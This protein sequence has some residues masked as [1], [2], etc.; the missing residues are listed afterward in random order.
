MTPSLSR[1]AG[2][3]VLGAASTLLCPAPA[4]AET[5]QLVHFTDYHSHAVASPLYGQSEWGGVAR[6][7]R[8]LREQ[9]VGTASFVFSGGD[10]LNRGAPVWSDKYRC[11]EWPWFD[12]LVDAMALGNHDADYGPEEFARCRASIRY[13]VLAAN[14]LDTHGDPLLAVDGHPYAVIEREGIRIGVFAVVGSDYENLVGRQGR[15]FPQFV[16]EDRIRAAQRVVRTLR[17]RERVDAV[18]MIGHA[19][20]SE[21][22]RLAQNVSGIDVIFGSHS[23]R[24]QAAATVPGTRTL[25]V[26]A[27]P[28]AR[29]LA[30][31]V[32]DVADHRVI[33]ASGEIIALSPT[34]FQP[35][36]DIAQ[37]V[38]EMDAQ[39]RADPVF[40]RLFLPVGTAQT[41]ISAEECPDHDCPLSD[42][43]L[44]TVREAAHADV[45]L[46]TASTFRE[47]IAPGT[48]TEASLIQSVPYDNRLLVFDTSGFR[49]EGLLRLSA[50]FAG[51][52]LVLHGSGLR[53][54]IRRERL[55]R[56]EVLVDPRDPAKGWTA[57]DPS[58]RYRVVTTDFVARV[59]PPYRGVF[60]QMA[61]MD[62]DLTLRGVLLRALGE[63][64]PVVAPAADG[65]LSIELRA[66]RA[67]HRAR[68]VPWWKRHRASLSGALA[69]LALLLWGAWTG[70]RVTRAD[71]GASPRSG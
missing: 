53:V 10:M 29:S 15:P 27:G 34:L 46:A 71:P 21:D 41:E 33:A 3:A 59:L 38:A 32:L 52:D 58:K 69:L 37:R 64:S 57:I 24:P 18:V 5:V 36:P 50:Q 67:A 20:T 63:R 25:F 35:D 13:P 14:L 1:L 68:P 70:T 62:T 16:V 31:V 61:S 2:A 19:H 55:V 11:V 51:S 42:F 12:G 45:A 60:S 40:E 7:I 22:L 4:S 17:S 6:L 66:P 26:A 48:I 30:R 47:S 9:T 39:L 65:R 28:Y 56:A 43:A 49:L 23:H 54:E 44:D 8:W